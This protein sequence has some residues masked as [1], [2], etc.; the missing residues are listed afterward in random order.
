MKG[1]LKLTTEYPRTL[2]VAEEPAGWVAMCARGGDP[3]GLAGLAAQI[4]ARTVWPG[5]EGYESRG[6]AALTDAQR[7]LFSRGERLYGA[8]CAS[9][10]QKD[11]RGQPGTAPPLDG[12]EWVLGDE[13]R[14]IKVMLHGLGGEVVIDG[15]VW[16]GDMPR[17]AARSDEQVASILTYVRRS[18][19]NEAPPVAPD[20]VKAIRDATSTRVDPWT[21]EEL[22]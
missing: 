12:T 6:P 5:R 21:A 13:E 15:V 14:L 20:A 3:D 22:P 8:V 7:L 17:S 4:D 9:C 1:H 18:F 16:N 19:G 2:V 10:H 11:G